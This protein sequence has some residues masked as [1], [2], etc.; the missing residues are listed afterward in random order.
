M[1]TASA[2]IH[3]SHEGAKL[4]KLPVLLRVFAASCETL[5]GRKR[6]G[7]SR[8]EGFG[9][10]P[11]SFSGGLFWPNQPVEPN[12]HSRTAMNTLGFFEHHSRMQNTAAAVLAA[13]H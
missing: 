13:H 10:L 1:Y 8:E 2:P 4:T 9:I 6:I 11:A 3:S 12:E 5:P 7:V